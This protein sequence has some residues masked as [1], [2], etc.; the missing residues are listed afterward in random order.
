MA[1]GPVMTSDAEAELIGPAW[2]TV[3]RSGRLAAIAV[4]MLVTAGLQCW[5]IAQWP[6]D[7][8]EV[9][10][11]AELGK[12]DPS[13]EVDQHSEDSLARRLP[14][15]VPVWYT[16]QRIL[17]SVLPP[18]EPATRLL[19]VVC[20]ILTV[21]LVFVFGWRQRSLLFAVGLVILLDGSQ[22][23]VWLA[24]QN[25]FYT[26]ATLF[27]VLTTMAVWSPKQGKTMLVLTAL[28]AAAAMLSHSM[29]LIVVGVGAAAAMVAY[30][31]GWISRRV[32]DRSLLAAAVCLPIYLF[33]VRPI[34]GDWS[35]VGLQWTNPLVSF[36][37][38]VGVPT[39]ALSVFGSVLCL[40]VTKQ[41]GPMCWWAGVAAGVV[42]F[43]AAVPLLMPVWN[44][45]YGLLFALPLW[46]TAA[47]AMEQVAVRLGSRRLILTWYACV[48]LLLAPKLASHFIDGSRHD[49][50][51]AARVVSASAE[52]GE[53]ILANMELRTKYYLPESFRP[54]VRF[55][56]ETK[57]LPAE[58]CWVVYG[59]NIWDPVLRF[60]GRPSELRAQIA[61]RRF[62]EQSHVVRVY[63]VGPA[64]K[65]IP[66]N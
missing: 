26:T 60:P 32:L 23:L 15:L 17:L 59:S 13:V 38:H 55:W 41:R 49:Y 57:T 44:P 8:D 43:V 62:D 61:R 45:R 4:V 3:R 36:V 52:P 34:A 54:A 29:I 20:G 50:R 7:T 37:A 16:A 21:T 10:S 22:L 39:L 33:H 14:R 56:N 24:A 19:S 40:V 18:S 25:R 9:A 11:L 42:V 31:A 5:G 30:P 1:D 12:I 46:M 63:R 65:R 64:P 35:G 47:Y 2:E 53:S 58:A 6:F 27:L 66:P 51:E 28:G 48:A